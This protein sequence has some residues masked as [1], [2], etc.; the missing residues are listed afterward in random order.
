MSGTLY[1]LFVAEKVLK[2]DE[3]IVFFSLRLLLII[4]KVFRFFVLN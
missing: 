2:L 4:I 3:C 1:V